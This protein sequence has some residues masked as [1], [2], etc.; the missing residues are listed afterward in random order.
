VI[1]ISL[2]IGFLIGVFFTIFLYPVLS[3]LGEIVL[4]WVE[5]IK[6]KMSLKITNYSKEIQQIQ[7]SSIPSQSFAIGF[8][9][10]EGAYEDEDE[11]E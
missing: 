8:T 7:E 10:D 9:S 11:D 5:V 4:T 6:A 2:L 1:F 3:G